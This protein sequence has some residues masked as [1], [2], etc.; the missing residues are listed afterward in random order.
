[1]VSSFVLAETAI[2]KYPEGRKFLD[3]L[4]KAGLFLLHSRV[5]PDYIKEL[6]YLRNTF[7]AV[8]VVLIVL[9]F[10]FDLYNSIIYTNGISIFAFLWL[11]LHFAIH[12]KK[13]I[14]EASF[15]CVKL[16]IF[17]WIIFGLDV[18]SGY[19]SNCL[20]LISSPFRIFGVQDWEPYKIAGFLSIFLGFLGISF[21]VFS[22]PFLLI[23]PTFILSVMVC[24]SK[25]SRIVLRVEPKVA[26]YIVIFYGLFVNP[27][28]IALKTKGIF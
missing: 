26:Y 25:V 2:R 28:L 12:F 7:G 6:R 23:I 13:K 10:V 22:T 11:S 21:V 20:Y 27:T 4:S 18:I 9:Y 5:N 14:I 3:D 8:A 16:A 19:Q 24:L 15:L 1:M 17:P